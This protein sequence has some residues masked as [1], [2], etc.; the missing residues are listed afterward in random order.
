[1]GFESDKIKTLNQD[2]VQNS[3]F[4]VLRLLRLGFETVKNFCELQLPKRII[5]NNKFSTNF[6]D[7]NTINYKIVNPSSFYNQMRG[8]KDGVEFF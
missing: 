4:M 3:D 7:K 1:M 2:H 8:Q 6:F 5:A